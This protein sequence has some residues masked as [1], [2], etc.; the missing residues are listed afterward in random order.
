MW[1]R[2]KVRWHCT[3]SGPSG[4]SA[5][6]RHKKEVHKLQ[7]HRHFL[8]LTPDSFDAGRFH[9]FNDL[10]SPYCFFPWM[11]QW[12]PALTRPNRA[13]NF[14]SKLWSCDVEVNYARPVAP[15]L[16]ACFSYRI[17]L[18]PSARTKFAFSGWRGRARPWREKSFFFL[19]LT[20]TC[21]Y[22]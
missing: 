6:L 10:D 1:N 12:S 15:A 7:P 17:R 14:R 11:S 4:L 20:L 21:F 16:L 19:L 22:H 13:W 18:Q 5:I 2:D 9:I 3:C 8:H